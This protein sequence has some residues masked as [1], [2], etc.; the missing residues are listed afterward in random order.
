LLIDG[1]FGPAA[2]GATLETFDPATEELLAE[3]PQAGPEDV[4]RAVASGRRAL[5]GD[6]SRLAPAE[7]GELL[8][9]L[10]EMIERDADDLAVLETLDSGKPLSFSHTVDVATAIAQFRYYAGW[11]TKVESEVLP[12]GTPDMHCY[13]RKEPIGVCGQ[14]VPWNY[15]LA[16]ASL[17]V[18]P[19]LAAGCVS[20]LKPA[21]ETPLTALRLGELAL[22][23][24][25]PPG[26]LNVLPGGAETG[27][28]IV[29]HPG[30]DKVSFTGSTE[31]GREIAAKVGRR[32]A[33][34]SLELGGKSPNI[35]LPDADLDAAIEGSFLAIYFNT[36]QSC[37]AGSRL[38][39][40]DSQYDEVVERLAEKART[41]MPESGLRED[42]VIGPV[43][44][45]AQRERVLGY[46]EQGRSHGAELVA[47][48]ESVDR[49]GFFVQPTLFSVDRDDEAPIAR[50]EIFGPVL[51][52]LRYSDLDEVVRRANDT[53]YGLAAGVWTRDVGSAHRVAAKLA[54]GT[55]YVNNWGAADAAVPFGG[56][57]ASGMGRDQGRDGIE[58]YLQTKTV[59][60]SL[61]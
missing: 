53:P 42:T 32:L 4:E 15:P 14:I 60:V 20:L 45:A 17:K 34:V 54:A 38:F 12:V 55:V 24:G 56:I 39:V 1:E 5:E 9:R 58:Q 61:A 57:K 33:R 41:T 21:P 23:A 11:P 35:I 25:I 22:E 52:A 28:A 40:H 49:P 59:W 37:N 2:S 29:E 16:L 46:I 26:V 48:G 51:V 44:S 13:R 30:V 8:H 50:E 18:A 47:G 31:V 36:G 43:V 27:A 7:R 10:A 3:V 6:W 19:A